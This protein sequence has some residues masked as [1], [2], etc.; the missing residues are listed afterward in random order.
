MKK[1]SLFAAVAM[2]IVSAIV[3]TS[4]TY[5]W[6]AASASVSMSPISATIKNDQGGILLST[7]KLLAT[8]GGAIW[9]TTLETGDF[10]N[11]EDEL[12]P[13]SCTP[14]ANN[15]SGN[16]VKQ[17]GTLTGQ[18]F[19]STGSATDGFIHYKVYAKAQVGGKLDVV[20]WLSASNLPF[21]Y[22]YVTAWKT[23]SNTPTLQ[24]SPLFVSEAQDSY[25]PISVNTTSTDSNGNGII[26]SA[27]SAHGAIEGSSVYTST[28][29]DNAATK[30]LANYEMAAGDIVS[31][32]VVVWAEGQDAN[33][34]G[35][36][37]V[38]NVQ[39]KLVFSYA[40][41]DVTTVASGD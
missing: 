14:N 40:A 37:Q 8:E 10:D 41:T 34:T 19:S 1:R 32:D 2:L 21:I 31:I 39:S 33:C 26:D 16:L 25:T 23:V 15:E 9:K 17:N 20:N 35:T 38:T 6:F 13:I 36:V 3:L 29:N 4:A 22:A 27:D 28:A 18:A 24:G 30:A 11:L 5:A 12:V 7:D